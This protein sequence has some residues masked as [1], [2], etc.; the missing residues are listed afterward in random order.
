MH[1]VKLMPDIYFESAERDGCLYYLSENKVKYL[2]PV[3][4]KILASLTE[5]TASL[6]EVTEKYG[7]SVD[8]LLSELDNNG[9]IYIYDR[10]VYTEK[11]KKSSSLEIRGFF[12][13][14]PQYRDIYIQVTDKCGMDCSVCQSE[15]TNHSCRSCFK[16]TGSKPSAELEHDD[17]VNAVAQLGGLKKYAVVFSGGDPLL[18]TGKILDAVKE[19]KKS[20]QLCD[21]WIKTP[22]SI[23]PDEGFIDEC[24]SLGVGFDIVFVGGSKEVCTS[25]TGDSEAYD[26]AEKLLSVCRAK[27]VD[28]K[29]SYLVPGDHKTDY[30]DNCAELPT[31][32]GEYASTLTLEEMKTRSVSDID[33]LKRFNKCF[34]STLALDLNGDLRA[35]PSMNIVYGN[36]KENKLY[37]IFRKDDIEKYRR[38]S[39]NYILACSKCAMKF[40]CSSDCTK[41]NIERERCCYEPDN[42]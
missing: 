42:G 13:A 38:M 41:I 10:N 6:E 24:K 12:E 1:Y 26:R 31:E 18:N 40:V 7:S 9:D 19:L 2:S 14:T 29:V 36:L 11:A 16:W 28:N 22:V 3:Q 32:N 21:I 25:M 17:F 4:N 15:N 20:S 37:E 5:E 30:Y 39:K 35:C 23:M 27:G 8:E 33:E 34:N